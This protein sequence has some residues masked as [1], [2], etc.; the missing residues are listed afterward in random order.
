LSRARL[1]EHRR[2]WA[3]KPLLA[4]VY[5]PW[6]ELLLAEVSRGARVLEVGAGPGTLRAFAR[7]C[8]PDLGW[9]AT[10][11]EPC[12]WNDVAADASRLPVRDGSAQA[13]LGLDVLHHLPDPAAFFSEA[14]RVLVPGGRLALV[15]PWI[16]PLSWP[17]YRF[18]HEED[19]RL[20]VDPW[21]PFPA[22]KASFDGDAALP[23]RIVREARQADWRRFGLGSPRVRRLNS[24]AYLLSLGF[25]QASLLP[26]RLAGAAQSLDRW[27]A[28]LV[29]LTALRA[30]VVWDSAIGQG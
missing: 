19:C 2:L 23:W 7:E 13:V 14:A 25:R 17:V 30:C 16:S 3:T 28:P 27:T 26:L 11:L 10:D 21:R 29:S 6:F 20:G 12:P 9:L 8:R 24:F 1:E 4:R 5:A 15:E 22:D 18:L